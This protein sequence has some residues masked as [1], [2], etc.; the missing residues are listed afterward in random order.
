MTRMVYSIES[1]QYFIVDPNVWYCF[2]RLN[3]KTFAR[4]FIY[5]E[6][7]TLVE[8]FS[9]DELRSHVRFVS[10]VVT[11][12]MIIMIFSYLADCHLFN[13][14]VDNLHVQRTY[15]IFKNLIFPKTTT[16]LSSCVFY[17]IFD[18]FPTLR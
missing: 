6:K 13:F 3:R 2:L 18:K 16:F 12:W 10:F 7:W 9:D 14:T 17:Q 15:A 1:D 8:F 5:Y 11:F 4:S